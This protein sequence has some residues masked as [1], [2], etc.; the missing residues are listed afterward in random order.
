M[1]EKLPRKEAES[2]EGA[3]RQKE[4]SGEER[5]PSLPTPHPHRL[6]EA[7][8]LPAQLVER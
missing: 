8:I 2:R 5:E 4:S 3:K 6:E 7:R 1:R